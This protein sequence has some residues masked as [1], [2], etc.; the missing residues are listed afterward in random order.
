[1]ALQV[2]IITHCYAVE[3]EMIAFILEIKCNLIIVM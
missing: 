1:M 2:K 3:K